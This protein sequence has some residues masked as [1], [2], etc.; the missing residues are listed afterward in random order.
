M[1]KESEC[2]KCGA[3]CCKDISLEIDQPED[4]E[5]FENLKWF[6]AHKK[7]T[8]YIDNEDDWLVE[9][10]TD[11]KFLDKENKCTIYDKRYK[12]CREHCP[13]TCVVN[14]GEDFFKRMFKSAEEIDEYMKEIG[15]F[16]KY[17]EEKR[18]QSE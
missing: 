8:I 3:K 18:K 5:D 1:T 13:S 10:E 4:F 17:Q 16:E 14:G 15:F 9:F 11:C 7:V 12:V 2:G 6:L